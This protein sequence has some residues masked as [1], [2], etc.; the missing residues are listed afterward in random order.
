MAGFRSQPSAKRSDG[1]PD[2][3]RVLL[4]DQP[5]FSGLVGPSCTASAL[6]LAGSIPCTSPGV[7]SGRRTVERLDAGVSVHRSAVGR[8]ML[9]LV[10]RTG[11]P[12]LGAVDVRFFDDEK[13]AKTLRDEI[14]SYSDSK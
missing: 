9:L 12:D 8:W 6:R 13:T 11:V 2:Q 4:R 5:S 7:R 1:F 3:S 10:V 14:K